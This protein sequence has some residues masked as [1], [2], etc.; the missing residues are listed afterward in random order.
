MPIV[1]INGQAVEFPDTL[2]GDALN[3]AVRLAASQLAMRPADGERGTGERVMRGVGLFGKGVNDAVGATVGVIPDAVGAGLRFVGLP[4]SAPG[5]YT[6]WAQGALNAFGRNDT[7]ETAGEKAAY[8]AGQ[9]VGNVVSTLAPAAA[10]ANATRAGTLVN[11]VARTMAAQPVMQAASGAVGGAVGE[12]SDNPYLGAAA[13]MAV[14][15][16]VGLARGVISPGGARTN[17]ET[18]RLVDVARGEGIPL[19][20]GQITGNRPLRTMESVFATLP[21]TAGRQEAINQGQRGAFNRAVLARA[22]VRGENLATPNV[23]NQALDNAG[24]QM[25]AIYNQHDWTADTST[26]RNVLDIAREAKRELTKDSLLPIRNRVED[27]VD[28]LS[29]SGANYTVDGKAFGALDSAISR[30]LRTSQDGKVV[31]YLSSLQRALRDAYQ[32]N[33]PTADAEALALARRQYANGILIEKAMNQTSAATT[34]GNIPPSSLATAIAAGPRRN[35]AT[36][37]GDLNDLARVGKAFIQDATPNSGTP[38]RSMIMDLLTGG[39]GAGGALAGGV[40]GAA[41]GMAGALA[42][43]RIAQAAYNTPLMQSYLTNQLAD[44]ILPR[45]SP[46]ALRAIGATQAWG[47]LAR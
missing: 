33:L 47:L 8:G 45:V 37:F 34:A 38:E 31:E 19:T 7:P 4:S 41:L 12:A 15:A 11:G 13:A 32:A 40:E 29:T 46:Q 14:P 28:K 20:P 25:R 5:Q 2:T 27:L 6:K 24:S 23:V 10:V 16:A 1:D 42:G 44:R 39:A 26:M 18:A 43:P 36:G 30:E 22:G 35:Y 21:S 17:P 9:G 3:E